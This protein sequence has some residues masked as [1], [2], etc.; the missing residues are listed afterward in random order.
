MIQIKDA[1]RK[2]IYD[3]VHDESRPGQSVIAKCILGKEDWKFRADIKHVL[4]PF[5][6]EKEICKAQKCVTVSLFPIFIKIIRQEL[7]S[8]KLGLKSIKS[9]DTHRRNGRGF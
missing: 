4:K 2:L 9:P 1:I 8:I 5:K 3:E 6:E 7:G